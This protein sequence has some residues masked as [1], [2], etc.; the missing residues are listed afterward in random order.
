VNPYPFAFLLSLVAI[1]ASYLVGSVPFGYLITRWEKGIDIRTVGSGNLGATNVGR[2]LGFRFFLLVLVLDL[3]K[4]LLTTAGLPW[5]VGQ[6]AGK[7]PA[8]LAVL[9]A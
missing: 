1:A 3:L 2:I 6:L 4:G 8:D 5:L 9:V 7:A